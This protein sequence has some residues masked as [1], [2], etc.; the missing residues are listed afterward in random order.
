MELSR[1]ARRVLGLLLHAAVL[2]I[3]TLAWLPTAWW[4]ACV[5]A[6]VRVWLYLGHWPYY[7]HP[8]PKDIP[9]HAGPVPEWVELASFLFSLLLLV[10]VPLFGLRRVVRMR[11]WLTVSA[12]LWPAAWVGFAALARFDPGG[13]LDWI[14]D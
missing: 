13:V 3:L 7:G 2:S 11:W 5:V 4:V 10:W 14:L 6:A 8:D 12:V 9:A 1:P